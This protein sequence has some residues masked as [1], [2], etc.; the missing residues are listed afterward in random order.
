LLELAKVGLRVVEFGKAPANWSCR[1]AMS[2]SSPR[3]FQPISTPRKIIGNNR[4]KM[5]L[6]DVL[7]LRPW[8]QEKI[9]LAAMEVRG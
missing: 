8:L 6:T 5:G 2:V 4:M 7:S 1:S 9:L 3:F